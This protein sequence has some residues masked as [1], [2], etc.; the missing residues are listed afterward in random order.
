[1]DLNH[2]TKLLTLLT[3]LLLA[4][5]GV[6]SQQLL[7]IVNSNFAGS[8]STLINPSA[9][10]SSKL[11]MDINL[12]TFDQFF[13]NDYLYI[14]G[15]DYNFFNFLKSDPVLPS[16]GPD[17]LPFDRYTNTRN[18]NV[19]V[20]TLVRGPAFFQNRGRHAFAIHTGLRVL[21]SARNVPYEMANF[22]YYGLD[23]E[24]QQNILY[25]DYDF[26][27]NALS[28]VEIGG[29]YSYSV[30]KYGFDELSVGMT[31]KALLGYAGAYAYI[32]NVNYMIP[33]D[34]ITDIRNM[35]VEAGYSLPVDYETNDFPDNSGLIKGNGVG[36]D[37]GVTYQRKVRT[38][39]KR[40]TNKLCRQKY[41]DYRYRIGVSLLDLGYIRFAN[42]AQKH[43]FDDVS[44]YWINADTISYFNMNQLVRDF[45]TVFYGDPDASYR[46][47]VMS[48]MLPTAVSIQVDY[49]YYR[50]WYF[51]ATLVQPLAI[52][53]SMV[54]R[55]A[56][57]SI[58]PRYE[59]PAFEAA[60]PISLYEWRYPRVGLALRYQ[61]I[62][63]GTDNLNGFLGFTDF[64]GLDI[65]FSIKL[66]FS[67]GNCG[68]INRFSPCEN[69]EY[70]MW[71]K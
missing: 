35:R 65:Y 53:K 27:A 37:F 28:F 49:H 51:N 57:L 70:G 3:I 31:A 25:D 34:S 48:M 12:L 17:D 59:T 1:M 66:N 26:Y 4:I 71:K 13:D 50:N 10:N 29:T 61:F 32:D 67:K 9:L 38:Y 41:I 11:Y 46:G 8:N 58:T 43:A 64:T 52:G 56:Q 45:S 36:F 22:G 5:Q 30:I 19:F 55:P 23:Y 6:Q 40:R 54:V 47:D 33:N 2:K 16:Y 60:L 42:N 14:R 63:I 68:I 20:Q 44:E 62:T 15:K 24:E 39:Q 69:N 18:K 21:S 7:G